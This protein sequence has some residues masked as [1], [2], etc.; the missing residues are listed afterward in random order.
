MILPTVNFCPQTGSYR[1]K[2]VVNGSAVASAVH[3]TKGTIYTQ[4]TDMASNCHNDF[5]DGSYGSQGNNP[6]RMLQ[7]R[8]YPKPTVTATFQEFSSSSLRVVCT[9][10]N[11]VGFNIQIDFQNLDK[12]STVYEVMIVAGQTTSGIYP[13]FT[14][15]SADVDYTMTWYSS[16]S[17][18]QYTPTLAG[19]TT[20]TLTY[21]EDILW[22]YSLPAIWRD[23]NSCTAS[24]S[25]VTGYYLDRVW[26]N[27]TINQ[28]GITLYKGDRAS[29]GGSTNV[30]AKVFRFA[31]ITIGKNFKAVTNSS[32][33]ITSWSECND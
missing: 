30:G 27:T 17:T 28:T 26:A 2:Y 20:G 6:T 9:I 12:G 1:V 14:A 23:T 18:N 19:S 25:A 24:E 13:L 33:V 5:I 32:G 11:K 8:G 15:S 22:Q 21:T 31:N 4:L 3:G 29:N 7:F 10:P 16:S